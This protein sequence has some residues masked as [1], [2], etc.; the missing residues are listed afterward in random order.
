MA[1]STQAD[2]ARTKRIPVTSYILCIFNAP[3]GFPSLPVLKEPPALWL[4]RTQQ[5]TVCFFFF[6]YNE[7]QLPNAKLDTCPYYGRNNVWV[8]SALSGEQT[9]VCRCRHQWAP[10]T[11]SVRVL[12]VGVNLHVRDADVKISWLGMRK[13]LSRQ[14]ERKKQKKPGTFHM[15]TACRL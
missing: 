7:K 13:C 6:F 1:E 15:F 8:W 3:N 12:H 11:C 2:T 10:F 4:H 9:N 14:L 5:R